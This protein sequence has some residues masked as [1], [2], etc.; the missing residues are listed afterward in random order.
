MSYSRWITSIWYTFWSGSAFSR[1]EE[2]FACMCGLEDDH[3]FH[4]SYDVIKDFIEDRSRLESVIQHVDASNDEI[5]ELLGYM[6]QFVNDV[7]LKYDKELE[8][9][10]G[11]Q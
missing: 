4:W 5:T 2:Q 3:N 9:L 10:R 6:K 7:D 1:S 11:E 8:Q